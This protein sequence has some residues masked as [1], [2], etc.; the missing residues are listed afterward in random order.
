MRDLDI[1]EV[2][3]RSGLSAAT[4]RFYEE[5]GLIAAVGRRGLRRLFDSTVL[6]RLALIALG[7]AAGFSL[8]EIARLFTP[9]GRPRIDRQMLA[10]KAD[11]LDATI[12]EL[13]A[14]R[15]GLRHAAACRAP[16]H[17]ECPTFQRILQA[18]ASGAFGVQKRSIA[19]SR[20]RRSKGTRATRA[21]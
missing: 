11:E 4:L 6:E 16:S 15:D 10:A 21:A 19:A 8:D 18:A 7:R 3:R 14:M 20:S 1:A 17:M 13:T 2:A 5:K 9:D 12:R